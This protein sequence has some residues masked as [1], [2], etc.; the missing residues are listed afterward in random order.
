MSASPRQF[1]RA[2]LLDLLLFVAGMLGLAAYSLWR[3]R[4]DAIDNGLQ[5]SALHARSFE[6]FLTQ[7][8][9]VTEQMAANLTL[10]KN[11][12]ADRRRMQD[13]FTT[14]LRQTPFLRSISLQDGTGRIVV[15][16]NPGNLGL[17]VATQSYL[18]SAADGQEILR[19][20]QPW[21]G[22][23]FADGQFTTPEAPAPTSASTFIALTYPMAGAAQAFT[24][25]IA[26]NPDY[27]IN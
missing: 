25:L 16:S 5:V 2:Y 23:D 4:S 20:G 22:R 12:V 13:T 10:P 11:S 24:L 8:L 7:S 21:R 3:L 18:P 17:V 6:N 9:R 1:R 26:I 14:T 19:I 27:F 15:S